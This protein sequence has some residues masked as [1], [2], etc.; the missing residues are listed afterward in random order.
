VPSLPHPLTLAGIAALS[1]GAPRG[2][3]HAVR[4]VAPVAVAGPDELAFLERGDPGRA[5]ILLV[6]TALPDRACV[7]V[8][9]PLEALAA[10]L[11][12]CFPEA[13]FTE[14]RS[15]VHPTAIV[16]PGAKVAAGATV[17]A[18]TV[19]FPNVVLYPGTHVGRNCRIHAGAVLGAEGFRYS[20]RG[21][22]IPHVGGVSVGDRVDIG[23]NCTIDRGLLEDTVLGDDCKL[24]DQVHV[25]HNVRMG[26]GVVVA[27]Q[28]GISGSC[29]LED[30]VTVGGQVGFADHTV[31]RSG[32][33]IGAQSGLHGEIPAGETWLGT[34]ARPIAQMRRIYAAV[35][36]LPDLVRGR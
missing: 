10:V 21:T 26:R 5:G 13:P 29:V 19:L 12:A 22:R 36:W 9:D 23:P 8:A 32:A 24:D 25:G 2:P 4:G 35:R 30:G 1:Q 31:V 14:D 20:A 3:D 28:T 18:G 16:G 15:G 6:R 34:P 33:R 7:V 17:G 27:A 11:A